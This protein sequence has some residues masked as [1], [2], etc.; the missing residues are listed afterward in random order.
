MDALAH[1]RGIF[2]YLDLLLI[3]CQLGSLPPLK[4]NPIFVLCTNSPRS[5]FGLELTAHR[6][7]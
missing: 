4:S 6:S 5:V 7:H 3:T 2:F 1:L